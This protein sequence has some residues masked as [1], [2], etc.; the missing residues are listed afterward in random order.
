[1]G[2]G[3]HLV[4]M[5]ATRGS[6]EGNAVERIIAEDKSE[7]YEKREL[8]E[9]V[10]GGHMTPRTLSRAGR[11]PCNSASTKSGASK[12]ARITWH[13]SRS[14]LPAIQSSGT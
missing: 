5:P 6:V 14:L 12:A 3:D 2:E 11:R 8:P 7:R 1:M 13:T 10:V 4:M 9:S